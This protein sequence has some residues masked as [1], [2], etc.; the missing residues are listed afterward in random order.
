MVA[1]DL[2]TL[3]VSQEPILC[4]ADCVVTITGAM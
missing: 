3:P 2:N 4:T 1:N